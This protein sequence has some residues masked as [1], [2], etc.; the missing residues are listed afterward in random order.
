MNS[1]VVKRIGHGGAGAVV[2]GNTLASFD[3]AVEIGVDMIEFDVRPCFGELVLAHGPLEPYLHICPTL[4]EALQHLRQPRFSGVEL[5]VDVKSG[6]CE[7]T[8]VDALRR[9]GLADRALVSSRS[10]SVV[11][12]FKELGRDFHTGISVGGRL[13]R[14]QTECRRNWRDVVLEGLARGRWDALM[15]NHKL[16]GEALVDAVRERGAEIYCWTVDCRTTV[17]QLQS[18]EVS[19]ITTND[20]RLFAPVTLG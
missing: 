15:A 1:G 17:E 18:L 7:A 20:P 8:I 6:G 4:D 19:G 10:T 12:R 16:V 9:H 14:T 3:A 5:N 11:D 13:A 2:K